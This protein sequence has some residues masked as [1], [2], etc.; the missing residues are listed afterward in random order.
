MLQNTDLGGKAEWTLADFLDPAVWD[1]CGG[2]AGLKEVSKKFITLIAAGGKEQPLD[3]VCG[4]CHEL[5]FIHKVR[6]RVASPCA[7]LALV[8]H[9]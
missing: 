1:E 5:K 9:L 3:V 2:R 8:S 7:A 6:A 4:T